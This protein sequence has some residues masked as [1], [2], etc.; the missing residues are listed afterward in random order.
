MTADAARNKEIYGTLHDEIIAKRYHST[1]PIRRFA[2]RS[3]YKIFV[4]LVPPGSRVLDAGCGEGI[5]SVMLAK[6]GCHVVGVDLSQPNIEASKK[7]AQEN[8]VADK[9]E[10]MVGDI[11]HMNF[12]D[13]S[14]DYVVSSHVL[15][16]VPDFQQGARELGRLASKQVLIA[17]PTCLN[18]SAMV[19]LGGDKYWAFSRRTIY[20]LPLGFL[21]TL[22]A[23]VTGQEGVDESYAGMEEL[24]HLRR[25]PWRAKKSLE[26]AGLKVRAYRGSS[27][28]FPYLPFLLP[29]SW[30]LQYVAWWP[31]FRECGFG[32][33]FVC[34]PLPASK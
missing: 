29:I 23:L 28:I 34:D 19:L 18:L 30:A 24:I 4:D 13:H 21:L 32:V 3:Q 22:W 16:H 2:H 7:Y 20:A 12:P 10:F 26:K 11:E 1:S 31:V 25:F 6:S 33:T 17:I 9:C 14:F 15:E 27:Y 8:G 5:L